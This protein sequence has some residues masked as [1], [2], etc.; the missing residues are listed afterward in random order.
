MRFVRGSKSRGGYGW[1]ANVRCV[2]GGRNRFHVGGLLLY[3][4]C[5]KG[6]CAVGG[7]GLFSEGTGEH[8]VVDLGVGVRYRIRGLGAKV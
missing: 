6:G 1:R 3:F 8:C 5:D 2:D 7:P 4:G